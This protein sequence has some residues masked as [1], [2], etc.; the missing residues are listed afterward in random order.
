MQSRTIM[1]EFAQWGYD[2]ALH[3]HC[4]HTMATQLHTLHCSPWD[5]PFHTQGPVSFLLTA[6]LASHCPDPHRPSSMPPVYECA[7]YD[8]HPRPSP[9]QACGL[10][11]VKLTRQ[12]SWLCL[13]PDWTGI[14]STPYAVRACGP[15]GGLGQAAAVGRRLHEKCC[16]SGRRDAG[17]RSPIS[18]QNA[19]CLQ[20]L[21]CRCVA[22][23]EG[24]WHATCVF[25]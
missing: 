16:R 25:R 17:Q 10:P 6:P 8:D 24:G 19:S 22:C 4:Q 11:A 1:I 3:I 14:A 5:R 20:T 7:R 18:K 23:C 13:G 12:G 2:L 9:E 15:C 21:K